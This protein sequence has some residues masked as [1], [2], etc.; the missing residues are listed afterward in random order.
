MTAESPGASAELLQAALARIRRREAVLPLWWTDAIGVCQC[1]KGSN[2]PSPG[3]HPL[4]PNGLDDASTEELAVRGWWG[5]WP[6]ANLAAR[7][8]HVC[9]IDIDLTP[10]ALELAR[11]KGILLETETVQTPR[12]GLHIAL[13]TPVPVASRSLHLSDGRRL[14]EL[15]AARAY[16]VVPPSKIGGKRYERLS[17]EGVEPMLVDDPLA[18]LDAVLGTYGYHL[19]SGD[20]KKDY[21]A[22]GGIVYEG[23]GRHKTLVSYAGRIWVKGMAAEAFVGALRAVNEAQCVPPLPDEE[24]EAI[25]RHFIQSRAASEPVGGIEGGLSLS[26]DWRFPRTDAGNAEHLAC[27]HGHRLRYDYRRKHWLVWRGHWW[28]EDDDG[29]VYRLVKGTVRE[30]YREAERLSDLKEREAEAKFAIASENRQRIEATLALARSEFPFSDAG[31]QW[32]NSPWLLGTANGVVDLR[33]GVLRPGDQDDRIILHTDIRFDPRAECPRWLRFL[34]E[35]FERDQ[36]L[37]D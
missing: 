33:T 11:D 15:K 20:A 16:V 23:E 9:R 26:T 7:T 17:P 6:W 25:A 27:L 34:E 35:V 21:E 22:L 24:L 10:V 37:I 36:E 32:D 19:G 8:D 28:E 1:P 12:P 5:K 13:A 31:K 4:T 2:C 18:W 3:K 29:E 14:G 30:R